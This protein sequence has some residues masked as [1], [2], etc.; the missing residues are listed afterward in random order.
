MK[1]TREKSMVDFKNKFLEVNVMLKKLKFVRGLDLE[2][3]K[4]LYFQF[5]E[6]SARIWCR[7]GADFD[8]LAGEGYESSYQVYT[9]LTFEE[10]FLLDS[11]VFSLEGSGGNPK[12]SCVPLEE[13]QLL[14]YIQDEAPAFWSDCTDEELEEYWNESSLSLF[15][16]RCC[17]PFEDFVSFLEGKGY[18]IKPEKEVRGSVRVRGSVKGEEANAC[19]RR[20]TEREIISLYES[21]CSVKEIASV[22]GI[23]KG[24]VYQILSQNK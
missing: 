12:S 17:I 21:G 14:F 9:V 23:T 5:V 7:D 22:A 16:S 19:K 4:A 10:D 1:S 3:L 15:S 13:N 20:I 6:K 24:R 18:F 2:Q 11:L 8:V